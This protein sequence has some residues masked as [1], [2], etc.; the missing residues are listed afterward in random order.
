MCSPSYDINTFS[1][2][3]IFLRGKNQV[4]QIS[5]LSIYENALIFILQIRKIVWRKCNYVSVAGITKNIK[6]RFS[7]TLGLG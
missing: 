5:K 7:K 1:G 3:K 4:C 6:P 2:G